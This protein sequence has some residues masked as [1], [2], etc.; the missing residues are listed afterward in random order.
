MPSDQELADYAASLPDI[1]R[2]IM[3]AYPAVEPSRSAGY[4]LAFQTLAAHFV[5]AGKPWSFEDV[6]VACNDL[7]DG[8]FVEIRNG[9]FAHPTPLGERLIATLTGAKP[10][11]SR[12]VPLLPPLPGSR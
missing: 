6:Q 1:F 12:G 5:N 7:A 8:G 11:R 10:A 4:G 9:I 3:T 2:D